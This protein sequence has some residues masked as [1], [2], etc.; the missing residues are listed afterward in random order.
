MLSISKPVPNRQSRNV[1]TAWPPPVAH[2]G[3]AGKME[4]VPVA[5]KAGFS[6]GSDVERQ[7]AVADVDDIVLERQVRAG[8]CEL[9]CRTAGLI[10]G[11]VHQR[12]QAREFAIDGDIGIGIEK[13]VCQDEARHIDDNAGRVV[14]NDVADQ[15]RVS[16]IAGRRHTGMRIVMDAIAAAGRARAGV[17]A[18]IVA[19]RFVVLSGHRPGNADAGAVDQ[20][21]NRIAADND[22]AGK[23][24]RNADADSRSAR[25]RIPAD[26][27]RRAL[28]DGLADT[29]PGSS[30]IEELVARDGDVVVVGALHPIGQVLEGISGD[31][32]VASPG[33]GQLDA[34]RGEWAGV[35]VVDRRTRQREAGTA[36][37]VEYAEA[38]EG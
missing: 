29:D 7:S 30:C 35:G 27:E 8:A 17:K 18:V 26:R 3:A 36:G 28:K 12:Q 33:I 37:P 11:V 19:V 4:Q 9:D 23:G 25:D 5:C 2:G 15:R 13:I 21:R 16:G 32:R 20:A 31:R 22:A 6:R 24:C 10:D 14:V 38:V 1:A 34:E